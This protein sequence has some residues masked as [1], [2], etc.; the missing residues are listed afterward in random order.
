MNRSVWLIFFVFV[1]F[2][3]FSSCSNEATDPVIRQ[4]CE[5]NMDCPLGYHCNL[6]TGRC[7]RDGDGDT[8]DNNGNLPGG[9]DSGLP[10]DNEG[11]DD[12][13][14]SGGNKGDSTCKC[15]GHPYPLPSKYAN[16][17]GWCMEDASGDGI[18]NCIKAPN[19]ILVDTNE[20]GTPDYLSTDSDG[21]GIPDWYECPELLGEKDDNGNFLH[22][23]YCRDTDGDGVPD[24]R[25]PDSDGDGI[26]DWYE[27]PDFD[28]DTGCRDTSGNGIPDYLDT[29]SDGDG[30]PDWYECPFDPEKGCPDTDGDGVPDYLDLDSDGD[31]I[32]DSVECPDFH[33]KNKCPDTDGDGI[34][35]FLDLD[36]DGDGVPDELEPYCENLGRDC[37]LYW[38]CNGNGYSDMVELAVGSDIC[39]PDI[40]P[41]DVGI[42]FYFEL[43]F[44]G[45]EDD[46][47]L[48]FSPTVKM[49]DVFFSVDTTGSMGGAISNLKS[50]LRNTIIPQTRTR[51]TNSAFG[52]AEWQD[53]PVCTHGFS[54]AGDVPF[55]L[56]QTPTTDENTAQGGVDKLTLRNGYDIPESGYESLYLLATG[57]GTS[58]KGGSIPPY[59]GPGIGGA[60]FREGAIPIVLHITDARSHTPQTYCSDVYTPHSRDQA[61]SALNNI[62]ARVI[63]VLTAYNSSNQYCPDARTQ[64]TDISVS[65][66]AVV[67]SCAGAGRETLLYEIPHNGSGLGNA[68][69]NGIDALVKYATFSVYIEPAGDPAETSFD[70]ACFIKKVEALEYLPADSCA[71]TVVATPAEF[72]DAGYN[73]GFN[74]FSTGTSS[75]DIQGSRLRFKVLAENDTCFEPEDGSARSFK[76][77]LN[78]I[79]ATT[80]SILDTQVVTVIVPGVIDQSGSIS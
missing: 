31:G 55:R 20:D 15:F 79:D 9:G 33:L 46:D 66:G 18:P 61:V 60:G 44:E 56:L 50:S 16:N 49:A 39:N 45:D 29:D 11:N 48:I 51:I 59:T 24:Y 13:D 32:P 36:S 68:I 54:S 72:N 63:S 19:G 1:F 62:G 28:P 57:A 58:W 4:T 71:A 27:C 52:C 65:T 2:S 35:D 30:I 12:D 21:D 43:P 25:D 17:P 22:I 78:I 14:D 77:Y 10:G 7:A 8:G 41:K 70:T 80:G 75:V 3:V 40:T 42:D 26:P 69:V 67:P 76:V 37:R 73:N 47:D 64:L 6:A 53:F 74:N 23:P 34:P 5:S 38:D